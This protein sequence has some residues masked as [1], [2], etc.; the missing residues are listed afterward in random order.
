MPK[1]LLQIALVEFQTVPAAQ[2]EQHPGI[3]L[4]RDKLGSKPRIPT[5]GGKEQ[6]GVLDSHSRSVA[7][8]RP[9]VKPG[10]SN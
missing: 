6:Q 7:A 5:G 8:N 9:F 10:R 4:L 2:P 1:R 3:I